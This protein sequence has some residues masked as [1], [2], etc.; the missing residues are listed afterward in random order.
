MRHGLSFINGGKGMLSKEE[1][2]KEINEEVD[3]FQGLVDKIC[4]F[5]SPEEVKRRIEQYQ[6]WVA[7]LYYITKED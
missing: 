5:T 4:E 7:I 2:I 6:F 3:Y 1:L